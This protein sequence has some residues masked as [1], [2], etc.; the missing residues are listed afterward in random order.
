[1]GD[2]DDELE[3]VLYASNYQ[4]ELNINSGDFIGECYDINC[5]THDEDYI[6]IEKLYNMSRRLQQFCEDNALP[7]FNHKD[8]IH[9]IINALTE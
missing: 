5:T 1:M 4:K 2:S 7:I 3:P 6:Y 8:T 9:I